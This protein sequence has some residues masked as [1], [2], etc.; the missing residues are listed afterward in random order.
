[1]LQ[2]LALYTTLGLLLSTMEFSVATWQFWSVVALFWASE[3]LTR[4]ETTEFVA[5]KAITEFLNLSTHEQNKIKE[6][7]KKAVKEQNGK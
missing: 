7:H 5:V 3:S 6:L 4:R 2:R 1:M